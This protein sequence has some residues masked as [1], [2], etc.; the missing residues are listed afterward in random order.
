MSSGKYSVS[1]YG[2]TQAPDLNELVTR[3]APLVHRIA[4]HLKARLPDSVQ[5]EDLYQA[6][7]I[8]LIESV[9]L[10][11]K[12]Q[13]AKFETYA[14]IRVRGAML[15]ELRR[16]DWAPKSVHRKA[17]EL[18]EAVQVVENRT[19]RDASDQEVADEL[20]LSLGD[21]NKILQDNSSRIISV[22][23]I[24]VDSEEL[25]EGS[26]DLA[27]DPGRQLA[28]AK[29]REALV[30]AIG[31]LPEREKMVVSL[32]Y[33]QELNLREIGQVLDVSESRVS[34]IMSKAHLRLRA[35]LGD[36]A[37]DWRAA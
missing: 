1:A 20:G 28:R 30:E 32:Y 16:T 14:S 31:S 33:D 18:A 35:R 23:Q 19:G 29:F 17:R 21:Y 3:H 8:G 11:D 13:G 34:Q 26:T 4:H 5:V 24:G 10:Y 37:G 9:R 7:M 25:R 36:W 2:E 15:D 12:E 27:A 6:G 22:E